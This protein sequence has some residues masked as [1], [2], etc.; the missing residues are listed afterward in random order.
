MKTDWIEIAMDHGGV[1][2]TSKTQH[3]ITATMNW[4]GEMSVSGKPSLTIQDALNSLNSELEDDAA[5]DCEC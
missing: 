5:N 4:K 1:M 2:T 3:G